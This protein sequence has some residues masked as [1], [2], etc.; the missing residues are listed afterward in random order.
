MDMTVTESFI[1]IAIVAG[2]TLLTRLL[3]F[4]LFPHAE[5]APGVIRYLGRVLPTAITALL[6]VYC[7][8][9]AVFSNLHA[10]P[11][12]CAIAVIVLLHRLTHSMMCAMLGGTGFYMFLVQYVLNT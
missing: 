2:A 1:T 12:L 9:D 3:P 8:K 5:K 6:V 10:L 7:L 11:Q 4:L